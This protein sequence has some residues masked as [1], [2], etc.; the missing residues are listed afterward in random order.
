[1]PCFA[2]RILEPGLVVSGERILD[3]MALMNNTDVRIHTEQQTDDEVVTKSELPS[4]SSYSLP[5]PSDPTESS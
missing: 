2:G 4:K 3:D 1:M 5:Y